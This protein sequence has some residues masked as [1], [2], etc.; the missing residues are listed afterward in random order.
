[1]GAQDSIGVFERAVAARG[2]ILRVEADREDGPPRILALTFDIGRVVVR[3]EEGEVRVEAVAEREALPGGLVSLAEEDPWWRVL[4]QPITAARPLDAEQEP[5]ARAAR[6]G[7]FAL[8]FREPEQN[9]RVVR[10]AA[11]GPAL[12][13]TLDRSRG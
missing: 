13:V 8:R 12:R 10:V 2:R 9:P 1:M 6:L 3:S 5:V 11:A 7:G 4:G